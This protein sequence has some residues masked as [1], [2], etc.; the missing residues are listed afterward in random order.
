MTAILADLIAAGRRSPF[1]R[2]IYCGTPSYGPACQ[3]H[4][5]VYHLEIAEM[6]KRP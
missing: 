1:T 4:K 6:R 3:A 2:C 5:D